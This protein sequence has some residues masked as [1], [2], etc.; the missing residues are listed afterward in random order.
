M[1][2]SCSLLWGFAVVM[3]PIAFSFPANG[4]PHPNTPVFEPLELAQTDQILPSTL[5]PRFTGNIQTGSGEAYGHSQWG[6][7]GFMPF[8]QTPGLNT[9]FTE[10]RWFGFSED[11]WGGNFRLG[12]R[13]YLPTAD[14]VWG[15]YVGY[16]LRRTRFKQTFH[17][18]GFGADL[19]SSQWVARFNGYLPVGDRRRQVAED[20]V[21]TTENQATNLRFQGERLLYDLLRQ[22]T[23][24][25]TRQFETSAAGWDLEAG[26][27]LLDGETGRLSG[28]LGTYLLNIP[29]KGRYL[30]VRGRLVKELGDRFTSSLALSSDGNFGT[31][32]SLSVGVLLGGRS[33]S[34]A[35]PAS[36]VVARLGRGVERQE[37]IALD[38]QRE[39]TETISRDRLNDQIARNPATGDLWRFIHV[40]GGA[41]GGDGTV[42]N[43]FGEVTAG[44]AIAQS[45]GNDVIYVDAGT[46]PGLAGFII[47]DRVRV[48][49]TGVVQ[50]LDLADVGQVQLPGSGTG[51]LPRLQGSL[52][53]SGGFNGQVGMGNHSQLSGFNVITT[54]LNQRGIL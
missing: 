38:H 49:S 47:P 9:F 27:I 16:D 22:K 6:V 32:L 25:T 19:Q 46:N 54:D 5:L 36:S 43:P 21:T 17:Q 39:V 50:S 23:L 30:G 44:V 52:I 26:H 37:A 40:T 31:N 7:Q 15:G 42:E 53:N 20:Q 41:M 24:T 29:R 2:Y 28:Y 14:L 35:A 51:I 48:L 1:R 18:L 10:A 4:S 11:Q 3:I 12:Y 34:E 13:E 33:P 8:S 45:A